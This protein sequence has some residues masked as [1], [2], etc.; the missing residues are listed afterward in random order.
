MPRPARPALLVASDL[1]GTLLD[2]ESYDFSPARP[3]LEALGRSGAELVLASSKTR[4]EMEPLAREIGLAPALIA[5]NGGAVFVPGRAG[6]YEPLF[7]GIEREVLVRNLAAIGRELAVSPRGFSALSV[8]EVA[9]LTGLAPEAAAR[10]QRRRHDE[11]FLLAEAVSPALL[12]AAAERRG[13]RVTRG[14]RFLHLTGDTDKGEALRRLLAHL[15]DRG[16]RF[17]T[18]GLGD[19]ANDLPLLRAVDRPI[20]VPR[21]GGRA[22]PELAAA[23]PGAELAPFPGPAGWNVAVLTVLAGERLPAAGLPPCRPEPREEDP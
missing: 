8:E 11:P 16:R 10:A 2:E 3:A 13:L 12:N 17:A 1:D 4:E 22:D 15:A 18:V 19:A 5:E 6:G 20:V 9:D 7:E 21:S 14:G 23:L